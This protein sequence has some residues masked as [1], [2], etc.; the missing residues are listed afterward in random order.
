M[1]YELADERRELICQRRFDK[2]AHCCAFDPTG[3]YL[4]QCVR[5]P[6]PALLRRFSPLLWIGLREPYLSKRLH[7]NTVSAAG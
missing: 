1:L 6:R 3:L 7:L 2:P 4:G 5:R